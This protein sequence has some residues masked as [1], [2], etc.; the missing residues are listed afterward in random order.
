MEGR[1]RGD[2]SA[3]VAVFLALVTLVAAGFLSLATGRGSQDPAVAPTA[4]AS[5]PVTGT[6]AATSPDE[7]TTTTAS[8]TTTSTTSTTTTTTTV[9]ERR[10]LEVV[11]VPENATISISGGGGLGITAEGSLTETVAGP[12]DLTVE[13]AGFQ[14]HLETLDLNGDTQ[15]KVWLDK[16][17]QLLHKV[18]EWGTAG[19]PKQV[20]F[21]PDNQEI[22]VT[23]LSGSGFQVFDRDGEVIAAVELPEAGSV[24]VIFNRSGNRGYVSQMETASVYEIDAE[25]KEVLRTLDTGGIWTKVM[26]LSPDEQ[27]LWASNWVSSDVSEIDLVSGEVRRKLRTVTT[28]RGLYVTPDGSRLYVAG[29]E[30]GEIEVFDLATGDSEVIYRSGGAMR[31]LVG[32]P[33]SGLMYASDM[34]RH[35]VLVVDTATDEVSELATVDKV[36]NTIDLSPD[37]RVLYVSNRGRNNPETYYK[38]GPEW[39]TVVVIDTAT[40]EYLDAII[41]GNQ[42]TGLDVSPDGTLLAFSDFLDNRVSLYRIPPYDDLAAGG[43]GRWEAHLAEIAK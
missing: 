14:T 21:S 11:A 18:G 36:P 6:A 4:A 1:V 3:R 32:D 42:T 22:W 29:F 10:L 28:P 12:V 5:P 7:L 27:T 8:T 13:A 16:P 15:L 19:A 30:H 41:G 25:T 40:G 23:L 26:A 17:G 39:G 33:D 34:A 43:G 31:H 37:G 38:P 24:E 20:A 2:G 35:H 9:P